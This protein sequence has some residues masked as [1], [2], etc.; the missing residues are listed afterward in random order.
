MSTSRRLVIV[1]FS[2]LVILFVGLLFWPFILNDIIT[3]ISQVIWILLRLFVLSIGQ[4]Y[5]W[6]AIIVVASLFLYRRLAPPPHSF[7]QPEDSKDPNA[8]MRNIDRWRSLF[9]LIDQHIQEDQI[10]KKNLAHLLLSLYA[11]KQHIPADFRLYDALQQGEIP[12]PEQIHAVLFPEDPQQVKHSFTKLAQSIRNIPRKW[13]RHWTGQE[14]AEDYRMLDE[15]LCFMET[16][17]EMK[18][19]DGTFNPH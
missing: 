12:I 10:L 8:T 17:L 16:S 3:P 11:T 1:V 5:Y 7:I 9:T 6:A 18:N 4:Q 15:I 14:T 13:I 19:D 2:L